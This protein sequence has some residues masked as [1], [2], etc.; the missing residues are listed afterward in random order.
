MCEFHWERCQDTTFFQ[1]AETSRGRS[2]KKLQFII[3]LSHPSNT[4]LELFRASGWHLAGE[5][6]GG[7]RYR[8][9]GGGGQRPSGGPR[10]FGKTQKRHTQDLLQ[11]RQ[12]HDW[13]LSRRW[14][15]DQRVRP[16]CLG[17]VFLLFSVGLLNSGFLLYLQLH[18]L[19]VCG[20]HSGSRGGE[21]RR[22]LQTWQTTYVQGQPLYWLWQVCLHYQP[23]CALKRFGNGIQW[24][25]MLCLFFLRYMTI[26]DEWE[27]PEKQPFKD[28]V[29]VTPIPL[30]WYYGFETDQFVKVLSPPWTVSVYRVICATGLRTQTAVTSTVWSMKLEKGPPFSLMTLKSRSPLKRE[31]WVIN[32]AHLN[33]LSWTSFAGPRW[34]AE[35]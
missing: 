12:D 29:S 6:P 20:S 9:D 7:W 3:C 28:F 8:L 17:C 24:I 34:F 22:W 14:W 11:V 25:N 4:F 13:V 35:D 19:G 1:E 33:G 10:A 23:I 32:N 30:I 2:D 16:R 18:L 21:E 5:A 26:S 15:H 31:Q 27:T